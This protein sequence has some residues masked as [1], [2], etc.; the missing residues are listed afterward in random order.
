MGRP[1]VAVHAVHDAPALDLAGAGIFRSGAAKDFHG[2]VG[3]LQLHLPDELAFRVGPI[4]HP[5]CGIHVPVN[6]VAGPF[7][8]PSYLHEEDGF[9]GS[10]RLVLPEGGDDLEPVSDELCRPVALLAGLPRGPQV[11]DGARNRPRIEMERDGQNLVAPGQLR[12][13]EPAGSGADVAGNAGHPRVRGAPVG[14]VLGLHDLVARGAAE[15][16]GVHDLDPFVGGHGKD[17]QVREGEPGKGEG[18]PAGSL[19]VQIDDGKRGAGRLASFG[20]APPAPRVE[21]SSDRNEHEPADEEAGQDQVGQDADVGAPF[22]PGELEAEQGQDQ[23]GRC[24][25]HGCSGQAHRMAR[26]DDQEGPQRR[27]VLIFAE[28]RS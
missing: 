19:L 8:H 25:R 10:V 4:A 24:G 20:Q 18:E 13:D 17:H 9:H 5:D 21:N 1:V 16:G 11:A 6:A 26:D 2:S 28:G 12:L 27:S 7:R 15:L 22:D 14:R 3:Q 23:E